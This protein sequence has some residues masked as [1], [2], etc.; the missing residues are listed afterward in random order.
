VG[1]PMSSSESHSFGRWTLLA[2]RLWDV[3]DH[4]HPL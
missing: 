1:R 2:R 3:H 4:A